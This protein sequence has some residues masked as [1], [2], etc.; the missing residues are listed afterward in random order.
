ML[1]RQA[2][3]QHDFA[4]AQAAGES[5]ASEAVLATAARHYDWVTAWWQGKRPTAEQ[6]VGLGEMYVA[7]DRFAKN[8]GGREGAEFVRDAMVAYA[9]SAL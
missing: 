5:P 9:K 6:F 4:N 7:D 3:I 2:D 1:A 8:Y